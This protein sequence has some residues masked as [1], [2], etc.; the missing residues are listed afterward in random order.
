MNAGPVQTTPI[1]VDN[2]ELLRQVG[3]T[4]VPRGPICKTVWV[5]KA[6]DR[7]SPEYHKLYIELL[8]SATDVHDRD[9]SATKAY[10]PDYVAL[11]DAVDTDL[12]FRA[13]RLPAARRSIV[14]LWSA[15]LSIILD[16]RDHQTVLAIRPAE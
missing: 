15:K 13:A 16:P 12:L 1:S 4:R 8:L 11:V 14:G 3:F 9:F 6:I 5:A 10:D 2:P 7:P